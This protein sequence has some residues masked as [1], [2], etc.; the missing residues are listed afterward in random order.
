MNNKDCPVK[1]KK[2]A[3]KAASEECAE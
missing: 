2:K 3:A 1:N